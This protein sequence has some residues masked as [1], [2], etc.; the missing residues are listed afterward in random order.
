MVTKE[1]DLNRSYW[2]TKVIPLDTVDLKDFRFNGG[3][4]GSNSLEFELYYIFIFSFH[5]FIVNN[6]TQFREFFT[7]VPTLKMVEF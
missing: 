5:S 1:S 6:K 3:T 7:L 4:K 2:G